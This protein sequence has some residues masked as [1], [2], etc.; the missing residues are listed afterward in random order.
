MKAR[1]HHC[2]ESGEAFTEKEFLMSR[3]MNGPEGMIRQDYKLT[4][5]TKEKQAE[6]LFY[7]KTQYRLPPPK[8]ESLFKEENAEELLRQYVEDQNPEN[9]NTT[10]LLAVMLERKRLL[11][12]RGVQRDAEGRQIRIYEHKESGETF[13]IPDPELSLDQIDAVQQEV[14]LKL[15]WI[16]PETVLQTCLFLSEEN[17]C[18]SQMAEAW[19]ETLRPESLQAQSAGVKPGILD[20]YAVKVMAEAGVDLA[21]RI[22]KSLESLR[23]VTVDRVILLSDS[24]KETA[25][26]FFGDAEILSM[27]VENPAENPVPAG[28]EPE[29]EESILSRYRKVRDEIKSFVEGLPPSLPES[30]EGEG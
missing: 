23:G 10:F 6:A 14:A 22:P 7:W 12:E 29:S 26:G 4:A 5:W 16:Q 1:A 11:I 13:L 28:E 9:V 17:S 2:S 8:K 19:V 21:G 18:R 15:G 30:E 27:K 25:A 24:L 20:P 3:L